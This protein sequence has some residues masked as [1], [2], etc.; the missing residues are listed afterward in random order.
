MSPVRAAKMLGKIRT[1]NTTKMAPK[2]KKNAN[3][4]GEPEYPSLIVS[5]LELSVSLILVVTSLSK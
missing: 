3:D 2:T 5:T 4:V 1:V